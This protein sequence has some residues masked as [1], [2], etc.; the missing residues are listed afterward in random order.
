MSVLPRKNVSTIV[1]PRKSVSTIVLPRKNV[2]TIVLSGKNDSAIMFPGKNAFTI[3]LPRKS[4]STMLSS[5]PFVLKA[6]LKNAYAAMFHT[7]LRTKLYFIFSL[8]HIQTPSNS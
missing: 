1:L 2:S 4:V 6:I 3:V 5:F 8:L 7:L